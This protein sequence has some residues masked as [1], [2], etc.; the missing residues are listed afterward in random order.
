[1]S[2]NKPMTLREKLRANTVKRW[3][4][5]DTTRQQT[6]AEHSFNVCLFVEQIC[7]LCGLANLTPDAIQ[8]AIHHDIPE[9][10]TGDMPST[11]KRYWGVDDKDRAILLDDLSVTDH[12]FVSEIVKLADLLDAVL[13]LQLYGV[14]RHSQAV[15]SDIIEQILNLDI[16]RF[17][18]EDELRAFIHEVISWE[19][20]DDDGCIL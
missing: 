13:F 4:I 9:V 16:V 11:A 18:Y 14:G 12:K 1:M 2:F 20:I 8:L 10:V 15:R 17:D 3:H 5:I 6:V 7:R 19:T